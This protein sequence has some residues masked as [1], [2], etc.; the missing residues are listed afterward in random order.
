A[1][2]GALHLGEALHELAVEPGAVKLD[3]A[4]LEAGA[5]ADGIGERARLLVDLLVHEML[6]AV[7]LGH[8]RGP[9]DALDPARELVPRLVGE[10]DALLGDDGEVAFL[11]VDDVAGVSQDR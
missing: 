1:A 3:V 9:F 4:L 10:L 5:T 6:V 7:L 2:G 8:G 11:E